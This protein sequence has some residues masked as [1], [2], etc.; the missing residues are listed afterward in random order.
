MID[1][2][3]S[4]DTEQYTARVRKTRVP[5]FEKVKCNF[6][7]FEIKRDSR[8]VS[9]LRATRTTR[10]K[11]DRTSKQ[12]RSRSEMV[13]DPLGTELSNPT[14]IVLITHRSCEMIM[15]DWELNFC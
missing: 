3:T 10:A 11:S 6:L 14:F 15:K 7:C 9:L 8:L 1:W 13:Q 2:S 12:L 4:N 5:Q